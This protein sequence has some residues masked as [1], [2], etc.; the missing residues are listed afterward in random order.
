M[1]ETSFSF[2]P[3]VETIYDAFL[4]VFENTHSK[5]II[6]I[7]YEKICLIKIYSINSDYE[8]FSLPFV[9]FSLKIQNQLRIWTIWIMFLMKFVG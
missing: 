5:N 6:N 1:A 7:K 3:D 8:L 9:P 4:L 2:N